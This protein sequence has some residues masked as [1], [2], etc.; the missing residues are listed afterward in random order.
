[1]PGS[2]LL[3]LLASVVHFLCAR[4]PARAQPDAPV[5]GVLVRAELAFERGKRAQGLALLRKAQARRPDD[6]TLR[7]QF[8]TAL[9]EADGCPDPRNLHEADKVTAHADEPGE[10]AQQLDYRALRLSRALVDACLGQASSPALEEAFRA[11]RS[12]DVQARTALARLGL[13]YVRAHALLAAERWLSLAHEL[14]PQDSALGRD[15]AALLLAMGRASE[16]TRVL[17]PLQRRTPADLGL[18][19]DYAGAL[20]AAGLADEAQGLLEA[21][22]PACSRLPECTAQAA[23]I[24]LE[25]GKPERALGWLEGVDACVALLMV[26]GDALV[27]LGRSEDARAAYRKVLLLEPTH[28]RAKQALLTLEVAPR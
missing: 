8:A 21:A 14:A 27:R 4:T 28:G 17:A 9:L 3:I 24:A 23:R 5:H 25:A 7:A 11:A 2:W 13:I 15:Y 16:A 1:M 26:R 20:T 18:R 12:G 19:Q 22:R 10:P 6:L